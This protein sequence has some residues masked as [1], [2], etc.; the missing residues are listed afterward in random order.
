[1]KI[2][3]PI[4]YVFAFVGVVYVG[5]MV[6][7]SFL[8][9]TCRIEPIA[10]VVSPNRTYSA[11]LHVEHC[12]YKKEPMVVLDISD[13]SKPNEMVSSELGVATTTN[14]ALTWQTDHDLTLSHPESFSFSQMPSSLGRTRI[15]FVAK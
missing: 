4:L 1:M 3:K 2:L 12:N 6:Y 5:L 8:A 11:R 14:F 10:S 13:S 9:K 7:F 15:E